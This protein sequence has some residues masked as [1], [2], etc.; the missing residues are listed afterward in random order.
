MVGKLFSSSTSHAHRAA[1][2]W[3]FKLK[4]RSLVIGR[5]FHTCL[6]IGSAKLRSESP[7]FLNFDISN[8]FCPATF[9]IHKVCGACY[10]RRFVE[11]YLAGWMVH[12]LCAVY[13]LQD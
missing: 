12:S 7:P 11:L 1:F 3:R 6:G 10:T 2:G 9:V 4:E 5:V 8:P 13:L